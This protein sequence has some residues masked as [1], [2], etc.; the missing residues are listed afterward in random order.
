MTLAYPAARGFDWKSALA[1]AAIVVA[2]MGLGQIAT[3]P[4]LPWY[5]TLNKP[6]FTPPDWVFG[7]V[8]TVL[9]VLMGYLFFRIARLPSNVEGRNAALVAFAVLMAVNVGWSYAFFGAHSPTLGLADIVA[10]ALALAA[11]IALF[12]R[13]DGAAAA[14]FLPV[15]AWV[16]F[17]GALNYEIWRLN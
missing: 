1:A 11:T 2:A 5:E 3:M 13:I 14:G 16:A 8:W 6:S 17:A 12:G 10:Q 4:N 15:A 9:Y 7:P